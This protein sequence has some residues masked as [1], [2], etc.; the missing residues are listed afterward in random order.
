MKKIADYLLPYLGQKEVPG[1]GNNSLILGW[2]RNVVKGFKGGDGDISWCSIALM[3]VL[4][5][6][7]D[8]TGANPSAR[9]WLNVGERI[10]GTP[11]EDDCIVVFWRVTPTSWQGHVAIYHKSDKSNVYALG[12]NQG[13]A[14]N[15]AKFPK[16]RVLGYV[17]LKKKV[18]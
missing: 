2:I 9:S 5:E 17:K 4:K 12:A 13:D 10:H 11:P 14:I 7:Y 15:Y 3:N 18:S 6:D 16:S 1:A 8:I